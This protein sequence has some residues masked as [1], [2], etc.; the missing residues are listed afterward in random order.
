MIAIKK[1]RIFVF[2]FIIFFIN[3]FLISKRRDFNFYNLMFV[4]DNEKISNINNNS[5]TATKDNNFYG[6]NEISIFLKKNKIEEINFDKDL[7][8]KKNNISTYSIEDM[9]FFFYPKKFNKKS[10]YI[11][12]YFDDNKYSK[13]KLMIPKTMQTEKLNN[14]YL[15]IYLC[16]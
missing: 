5:N 6:I 8:K 16:E 7:F 1:K 10:N 12:S 9:I 13:C 15:T 4:F 3:I 11:I 14:K 2:F